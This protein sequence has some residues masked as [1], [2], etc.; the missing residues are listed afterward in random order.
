MEIRKYAFDPV[1]GSLIACP[2]GCGMDGRMEIM[3]SQDRKGTYD[4]V[5]MKCT[6][7]GLE[8]TFHPKPEFLSMEFT[9][10]R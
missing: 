4:D 8:T 6:H 9:I 2:N 7:C 1:F 5:E 10:E 3:E